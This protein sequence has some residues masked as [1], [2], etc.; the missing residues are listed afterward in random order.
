MIMP[1]ILPNTQASKNNAIL[2]IEKLSKMAT[3]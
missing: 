1:A 2:G 3:E